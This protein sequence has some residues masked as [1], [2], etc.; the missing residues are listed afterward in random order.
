ME[1]IEPLR[2]SNLAAII[3]GATALLSTLVTVAFS[4]FKDRGAS[5]QRLSKLDE[6][7]KRISLLESWFNARSR[8]APDE[9]GVAKPLVLEELDLAF[10]EVKD[11]HEKARIS[12]ATVSA[13]QRAKVGWFRRL[14]L[15]YP[16]PRKRAWVP[17]VFFYLVLVETIAY[18]LL[19]PSNPDLRY[20]FVGV[21]VMLVILWVASVA[22]E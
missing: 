1:L 6:A 18:P 8:I 13:Q 17:R 10:R 5:A 14:L 15:L 22:I 11:L 7:S 9:I 12:P 3:G 20:F 21:G 4:W 16:P 19:E 2:D